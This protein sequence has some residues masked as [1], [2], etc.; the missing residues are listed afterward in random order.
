MAERDNNGRFVSNRTSRSAETRD[1]NARKKV[2][3]P[4]SSLDTPTPPDGIKYR[5][6]RA[7][8]LGNED[9]K[10]VSMKFR[11]GWELV[12]PEEVPNFEM[13]I[14]ED[15]KH[16]GYIGV[17]GLML[18]KIDE[19]LIA[20]RN[21]Y[22]QNKTELQMEAV[23]N[24]LMKEQHPSMPISKPERQSRVSFGGRPSKD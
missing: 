13:P 19:D 1:T 2:W 11:E 14:M 20:Q 12:R 22:Y 17:G 7:E 10:N 18:C 8:Y 24:N 21:Q 15:G 5:W 9:R 16:A 4:A 23:D 3:A 6:I